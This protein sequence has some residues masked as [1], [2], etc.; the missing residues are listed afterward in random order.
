ML[1]GRPEEFRDPAAQLQWRT[2]YDAP[3]CLT[4]NTTNPTGPRFEGLENGGRMVVLEG[5]E[6][7]LTLGTHAFDGVVRPE[8]LAQD[9]ASGYGKIMRIN[10]GTGEH[11]IFTS[12]HRNPQGLHIAADGEIWSA[13][14]GP[15][16]GDEINRI[17]E[18]RN[19]G[20]ATVTYGTDYARRSWPLNQNPGSHVGFE[21]PVYSFVPSLGLSALTSAGKAPFPLWEG[22]LL[23][24]S[25]K[26]QTLFRARIRDERL[27]FAENIPMGARLRD[28]ITAPDG[29]LVLWTDDSSV[30]FVE[31][32]DVNQGES[33]AG[34]CVACHS[35]AEWDM[36]T[37]L[38]PNL[39][40]IVGRKVAARPDFRY[41]PALQSLG[42]RWTAERL[43]AFL[44]NPQ[45]FA[46]GTS[47]AF[48]GI[49]DPAQ[50]RQVIDYL[51]N[52][53]TPD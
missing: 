7:L 51:G 31:P 37:A 15:R 38:G 18:G 27:I 19:Y 47:M 41:S 43:D 44:A 42:G 32:T 48:P 20:W 5:E 40:G 12:G 26:G 3:P 21:R 25:L 11:R 1:E 36:S 46:P 22:D 39:S 50:R 28:V 13:E 8:N 45:G 14:H 10:V 2:V 33:L 4:L 23:I 53:A 30:I 35:L 52:M 24:G 6:I 16:G 17:E 29:R 34:T 49:A 9:P